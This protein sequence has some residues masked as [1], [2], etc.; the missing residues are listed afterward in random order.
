METRPAATQTFWDGDGI[1]LWS[2]A[3]ST[4]TIREVSEVPAAFFSGRYQYAARA[5][6]GVLDGMG[7]CRCLRPPL[8]HLQRRA[9]GRRI[10]LGSRVAR[11]QRSGVTSGLEELETVV[12][13]FTRVPGV[14]NCRQRSLKTTQI[15]SRSSRSACT[16]PRRGSAP[17]DHLRQSDLLEP[18]RQVLARQG[19]SL[20]GSRPAPRGSSH[21][22]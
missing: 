5:L 7:A 12:G 4:W 17:Q 3:S 11:L 8:Q 1:G 18:R 20:P 16:R 15:A 10:L 19:S 13:A 21:G 14:T 2:G 6:G 9:G 22:C